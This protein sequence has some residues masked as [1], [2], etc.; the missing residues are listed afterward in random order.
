MTKPTTSP[1]T[2]QNTDPMSNRPDYIDKQ[3]LNLPVDG[4]TRFP[5]LL[6]IQ[7]MS[8]QKT[9]GNEKYIPGLEEGSLLLQGAA[10]ERIIDGEQ[11]IVVI[12]LA[13]RKRYVEY[14]PRDAGGGFV[15]SYDTKEEMEANR[16]ETNDIQTT[17][18]YL[19]IEAGVEDPTPF[20]ITFDTISKL[21]SAQ[22]WAGFISQYQTLEGV[23]YLITGKQKLNKKKQPYYVYEVQ[24]IGWVEKKTLDY[25]K[26]VSQQLLPLFDNSQ[27]EEI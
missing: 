8:P 19:C 15:A 16:D 5:R 26:G 17:I 21:G 6:L 10:E 7:A 11:G 27:N 13:I 2:A 9:K 14:V 25:V 1:K 20:T 23:K 18:E 12:P 3:D 4:Q 24:P 22:K